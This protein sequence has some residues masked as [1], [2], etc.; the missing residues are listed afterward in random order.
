MN[1]GENNMSEIVK[2]IPTIVL[3]ERPIVNPPMKTEE[4]KAILETPKI[5]M[6]KRMTLE[7]IKQNDVKTPEKIVIYGPEGIGKSTWAANF[8]KPIFISTED[9]LKGVNPKPFAFPEA[10]KWTDIIEAIDELINN[11]HDYKHLVLDTLDWAEVLCQRYV[12]AR[13]GKDSIESYGWGK[14][15]TIAAEE[16]KRLIDKLNVLRKQKNMSIVL[17]AHS[18]VSTF[19]NPTGE[20]YDRFQMKLD[21]RNYA[22]IKEWCDSLFFSY[23]E[24][25]VESSAI[26]A[27]GKAFGGTK[28]IYPNH[29]VAWDAK[30]RYGL[31]KPIKIDDNK[32]ETLYNII[33]EATK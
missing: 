15:F 18:S 22:T 19:N 29:S 3:N 7:S 21:K 1:K 30:N 4:V 20:N 17:L 9:G 28:T 10:E 23:Y 14:G 33:K 31:K 25:I 27:K 24:T 5:T 12:V 16:F 26:G 11:N 2:K 8:E 6:T 13:D 32:P